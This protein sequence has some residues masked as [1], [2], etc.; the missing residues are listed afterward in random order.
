[1]SYRLKCHDCIHLVNGISD[2]S[3]LGG[4]CDNVIHCAVRSEVEKAVRLELKHYGHNG[5]PYSSWLAGQVGIDED[6]VNSDTPVDDNPVSVYVDED[7]EKT[8]EFRDPMWIA[9]DLFMASLPRVEI[10]VDPCR[11]R[12]AY[13]NE[14]RHPSGK[15]YRKRPVTS[16]IR[17]GYDN[18]WLLR[19][20]TAIAEDVLWRAH[21]GRCPW[22]QDK[23]QED[24]VVIQSHCPDV[25]LPEYEEKEPAFTMTPEETRYIDE[26]DRMIREAEWPEF[27]LAGHFHIP[28]MITTP[29][30]LITEAAL[31]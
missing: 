5:S 16:F 28:G 27:I 11:V 3:T 9:F 2:E 10:R 14:I 12:D 1:M 19:R 24:D 20:E 22:F 29:P 13:G 7:G 21:K 18:D 6:S 8:A 17:V 26:H 25:P 30:L 31:A 4:G 15:R 23:P